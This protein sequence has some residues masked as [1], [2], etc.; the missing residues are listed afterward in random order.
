MS[1]LDRFLDD[2]QT[3][4]IA[5]T[6]E[7][8]VPW[9]DRRGQ[10]LYG[11]SYYA[12]S[13]LEDGWARI[14]EGADLTLAVAIYDPQWA[15][16]TPLTG[17]DWDVTL[18]ISGLDRN[19]VRAIDD[20][21]LFD[22]DVSVDRKTGEISYQVRDY[23]T[24]QSQ[25]GPYLLGV[26]LRLGAGREQVTDPWTDKT[27]T[28][29]NNGNSRDELQSVTVTA[30]ITTN[31][32][33]EDVETVTAVFDYLDLA[34]VTED[35]LRRE[36]ARNGVTLRGDGGRDELKG[37][38]GRDALYGRG[39][40]DTLLGRGDDD[41]LYGGGGA[42]L[43]KG[44]KGNDFLGGLAGDDRLLGGKGADVLSGYGGDDAL[45][46]GGGHDSLFGWAGDDRLFGG[47]GRDLLAGDNGH[48][49]LSGGAGNDRLEGGK[50]RDRFIFDRD[51][52][53]DVIADFQSGL[54]LIEIR[55]GAPRFARL[56]IS[57]AA[58]GAL[59]EFAQTR[60]LL[61]GVAAEDLTPDDFLFT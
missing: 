30:T 35:S 59:V 2:D 20:A 21:G 6:S 43:L 39:G 44:G 26:D 11:H 8:T 41:A 34:D 16:F 9:Y 29:F 32:V 57:D 52:G 25:H 54:D 56:E 31:N 47:A 24:S 23:L 38:P 22:G 53:R 18:T 12:I 36:G 60:I 46:G 3:F 51:D 50:G 58:N 61:R 37:G 13:E 49:R 5:L 14:E 40:K 42:D 15:D 4:V 17:A 19:D 45:L 48:D 7:T 10:D 33:G 28:V 27:W 55:S 1:S